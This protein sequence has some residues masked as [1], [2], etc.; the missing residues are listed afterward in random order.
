MNWYPLSW[1]PKCLI[2]LPLKIRQNFIIFPALLLQL[3]VPPYL[4]HS[5]YFLHRHIN[6][7][8]VTFY[9]VAIYTQSLVYIFQFRLLLYLVPL[10]NNDPFQFSCIYICHISCLYLIFLKTSLLTLCC[11][12]HE[13]VS[14]CGHT[15][16]CSYDVN[17]LL[18]INRLLRHWRHTSLTSH[19]F[20]ITL[21]V[22][23]LKDYFNIVM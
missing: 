22:A 19:K 4:E 13:D 6:S 18:C 2:S 7:Y 5:A 20:Y 10:C 9:F 21:I 15:Q 3:V 23:N 1:T 8:C 12:F 17:N 11:L 16:M 14:E